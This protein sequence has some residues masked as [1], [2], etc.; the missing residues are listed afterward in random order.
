MA[1]NKK[2]LICYKED[3]ADDMESLKEKLE[4][5]GFEVKATCI[6]PPSG[7]EKEDGEGEIDRE[8]AT[9]DICWADTF[10]YIIGSDCDSEGDDW[11]TEEAQRRGKRI[12]GV[13]GSGVTSDVPLPKG[14][15]KYRDSLISWSIDKVIDTVKNNTYYSQTPSGTPQPSK[16]LGRDDC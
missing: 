15:R 2:I 12:V 1:E 6:E 7:E 8:D 11:E 4:N 16:S 5:E 3:D 13:F 9:N 14:V 10:L